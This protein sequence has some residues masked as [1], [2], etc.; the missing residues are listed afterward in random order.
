[1]QHHCTP[2]GTHLKLMNTRQ[3]DIAISGQTC[4]CLLTQLH[5]LAPV[6]SLTSCMQVDAWLRKNL[7]HHSALNKAS[8]TCDS[9]Q[10][11]PCTWWSTCACQLAAFLS[12]RLLFVS[13]C[14]QGFHVR[15]H[16]EDSCIISQNEKQC[17]C[18]VPEHVQ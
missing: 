9:D 7:S 12:N 5:F 4:C 8:L 18:F 3:A 13:I 11:S 14:A 2:L 1:M 17:A 10:V 15:Q 6:I 16:L